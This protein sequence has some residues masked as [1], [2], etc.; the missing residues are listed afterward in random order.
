MTRGSA[1]AHDWG[2]KH[3][4]HFWSSSIL[5]SRITLTIHLS[6]LG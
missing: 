1:F 3:A 6:I 2:T 4:F 5:A